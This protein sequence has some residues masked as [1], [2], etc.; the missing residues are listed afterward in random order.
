MTP[1]R[2]LLDTD[3]VI[4]LLKK[5][6]EVVER[7]LALVASKTTRLPAPHFICRQVHNG[8]QRERFCCFCKRRAG[9]IRQRKW[10]DWRC[11]PA[12]SSRSCGFPEHSNAAEGTPAGRDDSPCLG[13][14]RC[15]DTRLR[16]DRLS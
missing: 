14:S 6:P 13:A 10:R 3:I 7:F 1:E 5:R 15:C 9:L 4:N 16:G 11:M 2:L 8:C 12:A